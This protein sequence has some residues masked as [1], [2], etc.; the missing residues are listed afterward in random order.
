MSRTHDQLNFH[1]TK[2]FSGRGYFSRY[3]HRISRTENPAF[4]CYSLRKIM[5]CGAR[6]ESINEKRCSG[7][8]MRSE[9]ESLT[10]ET[11]FLWWYVVK[12]AETRCK[13]LFALEWN[14]RWKGSERDNKCKVRRHKSATQIPS[15]MIRFAAAARKCWWRKAKKF[16]ESKKHWH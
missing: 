16:D 1:L 9:K 11:W 10:R 4:S 12:K 7:L 14:A 13:H 2:V 6:R 15:R 5:I 3:V 8:W